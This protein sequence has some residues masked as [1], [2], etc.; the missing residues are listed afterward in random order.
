MFSVKILL[1]ILYLVKSTFSINSLRANSSNS[2]NIKIIGGA[3]ATVNQ[4][5]Y[6]VSIQHKDGD[7]YCG[8]SI[9]TLRHILTAG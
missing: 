3:D 4:F 8:G 9:I 7:Q 1:L 5:P 6:M 2:P